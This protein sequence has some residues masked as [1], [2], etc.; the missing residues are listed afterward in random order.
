MLCRG[1]RF[2]PSVIFATEKQSF[3]PWKQSFC[4]KFALLFH[5]PDWLRGLSC[6]FSR[7]CRF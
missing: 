7:A 5:P 2:P 6:F 3:R 1:R 4:H